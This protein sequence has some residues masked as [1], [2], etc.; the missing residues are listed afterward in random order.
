[1]FFF[2]FQ[3]R[4]DPENA[5]VVLWMTGG[6]GCS[7]ELAVFFENGPWTINPDDLSLTETKHGWDTNHHM[8]F[9]D[10]PINTGFS[11]SADSRDSCYDETCVSN[12]MLDFLSEFFKARPE[13]QGRPFFVTG[14]SYA[15]HYVPAVA[16]RVFHASK[17]GEVEPPI[18][19]QGLAIGNGLTDPAIQYGAYSDYALM[20]GLIGQALHDRLKMLYPSCRLALEVCD[21]LDFAFECLL[22]VQWCQMSQF[23]PIM[24]VNGGMNV[25]DI[26]KECEGPLC[27]R[28]FEVLD[29][30]LNQDD[31][32]EK[33]GVG[34]LRWEACNMEVHSEMMSD[35]GHNYDIVLPEMLAAGVRVMIYAGDQDFICNYVGNQQWVDVLPW[36]GAKRWAVAEDEPWTVE[37]VAAGTVKSVGP[38]SFVRVF[39]AGHMVPMDQ[40]KN[41]LDMIT[42]FTHGPTSAGTSKRVSGA[43]WQLRRAMPG[44]DAVLFAGAEQ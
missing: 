35:W 34:D 13:L 6:P 42:R 28:E 2:Y 24:L 31:V 21:G 7:S 33:L 41:A 43:T 10:Q 4:S 15:G 44:K 40:A 26:R 3:A 5:P 22:A 23:A 19:L 20:N 39:K 16:S 25:Y 18:N 11:Y 29:K 37:G 32:R 9:V 27:Y 12:D 30:Y 38:F 14:E 1:M 36:H 17:S 8:I